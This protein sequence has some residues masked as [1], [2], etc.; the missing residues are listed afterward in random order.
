MTVRYC[1]ALLAVSVAL[2]MTCPAS[3]SPP[4]DNDSAI[5][6][7]RELVQMLVEGKYAEFLSVSSKAVQDGL[8]GDSLKQAWVGVQQQFG[9]YQSEIEARAQRQAGLTIVTFSSRFELAALNVTVSLDAD[10]KVAGFFITPDTSRV[11]YQAPGYVDRSA[12]SEEP[13]TV[14][15]G[16]YPLP[17]TITLPTTARPTGGFP[18]VVLVHG[19]GSHDQ[20]ETVLVNKPFRDLA[21]GLASEGVA[22]LRY[23]KRTHKYPAAHTADTITLDDETIDDAV[24]A[25]RVLR[26]HADVDAKRV[27]ALGHSLGAV[28]APFIAHKDGELAGIIAMAGCSRRLVDVVEDQFEYLFAVDGEVTPDEQAQLAEAKADL[29]K[30]RTGDTDGSPILGLPRKY[31]RM[32]DDYDPVVA[33][34]TLELRILIVQGGRDYQ[35][36]MKDWDVW[37]RGLGDRPNVSFKLFDRCNHLFIAGEGPSSPAEYG[38]VGHVAPE[39]IR[40]LADWVSK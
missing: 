7:A 37:K 13:V 38:Q 2:V 24:A 27:Y 39:V 23:E 32:M 5:T 10:N 15:A 28:A 11:E 19:S 31:L 34:K 8:P 40:D 16:S 36:T 3:A 4:G 26:A 12:F 25:A 20:D 21:W 33:A 35:V 9:A 22:V 29:A 18:G 14:S 17:G 1:T 6:R 30:V